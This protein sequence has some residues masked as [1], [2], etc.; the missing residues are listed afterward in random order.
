MRRSLS[1]ALLCLWIAVSPAF[2]KEVPFLAGRVNDL[3]N[4]IG[5]Q[6]QQQIE[7]TL[8]GLEKDTGAQIA[9]LTVDSLEGEVIED[10]ALR[11]AETW[12]LGQAEADNGILILIAKSERRI[13]IEVGYGL[14]G[15]VPDVLAKRIIDSVM[16][17]QFRDGDFDGGV[18]GAVHS[19]DGLIRGE[20]V[21][22]PDES[23]QS[24]MSGDLTGRI[25]MGLMFLLVIGLFSIIALFTK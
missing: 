5:S 21:D 4:M 7:S 14:E 22:L 1:F 11:V 2:A 9:I 16:Q 6:T 18:Q 25:I 20:A 3:A 13:R 24:G 10:Y 8:E 17:P 15:P 19:L 12:S 23:S